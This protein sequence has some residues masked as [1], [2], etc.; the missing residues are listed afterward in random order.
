MRD[1]FILAIHLLVTVGKLLRPGGVRAVAAESLLLKHQLLISNRSRHRAPNLTTLDRVVLGLTTLFVSPR[2][3]PKLGALIKP[4]TLSKF[5]KALVQRKY[6]L[7]FSSSSNRRK[8]GPK[9]PC[10]ELI[11]AIVELK[12]RN[13]KFGYLRIAQQIARTFGVDIDKD[14]VRR[15]LAKHYRPGDSGTNGT[16]WLTFIAHAKDSL[17]SLDLF[18]C[19]SILLRSH[20][21]MLVMDVFSRRII[22]FGVE[23]APIDGLSVCRMLWSHLRPATTE[24]LEHR[25]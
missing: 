24:A 20:W 11:A 15:V 13:P 4:T 19:E 17:W 5:H 16:S 8:P 9:G 6:R 7:L 21:V 12:T 1:L 23:P 14:I 18:R 22:G 3:I 2:R 25:P 10:A